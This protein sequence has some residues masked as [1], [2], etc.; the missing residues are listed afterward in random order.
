M[1]NTVPMMDRVGCVLVGFVVMACSGSGSGGGVATDGGSG[2]GGASN[3]GSGGS[4]NGG[5]G[6]SSTGGTSSGQCQAACDNI[7]SANCPNPPASDCVTDCES[8]LGTGACPSEA[9]ALVACVTNANITCGTDGNPALNEACGPQA[10]AFGVCNSCNPDSADDACD[11]C[12]KT[13]CC[14][15]RKALA[16]DPNLFALADCLNACAGDTTCIQGCQ[17]QFPGTF[18]A[19]VAVSECEGQSCPVCAG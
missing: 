9:Q 19:A 16:G 12:S 10:Q 4:S 17:A 6:G 13:S 15:Q 3:G 18:A 7:A 14:T 2:T 8:D 5:S 11:V 1:G